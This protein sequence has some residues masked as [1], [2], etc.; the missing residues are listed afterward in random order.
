M[1]IKSLLPGEIALRR[2]VLWLAVCLSGGHC[3]GDSGDSP[4]P[5]NLIQAPV[6]FTVGHRWTNTLGMVFTGVPGIPA[7][8]IW[9][10]RVK[11]YR[12]Y[13]E[14]NPGGDQSWKEPGF[15]QTGDHPVVNVSWDD[16]RAFCA[17]LTKKERAE[18]R[19]K[20]GQKYRLPMDA[21]WSAAVGLEG[22]VG[23]SPRDKDSKIKGVYPWGTRWPPPRG[24]GNYHQSLGV[25][26]YENTAPVGSF[27]SNK[28]D[29][30]DMGGNLWQWC[31]DWHDG[32]QKY[33]VLRGAPWNRIGSVSL[34]SSY[35]SYNIPDFRN[36]S[37]G[38]RCVLVSDAQGRV[39]AKPT[40]G[41]VSRSV[42]A[43]PAPAFSSG[44]RWTNTL[45][46]VFTGV[47]GIPAFSIWDTRVRDYRAYAEA[48]PGGDQSWKEPGFEQTG[49]HPVVNVSWDD[50]RAFC[51]W[52]TK[53]ERAEGRIKVGQKYRLPMDAEWSAA[54]GLEGEVGGSP[55]DKNSKIK[56]AYPWGTQWPAPKGAGNY[57]PSLGGGRPRIHITRG[58]FRCE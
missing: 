19:I 40:T 12:A 58:E 20:V 53:K 31:E 55:R 34:L 45:G 13:A 25:D 51:A 38:F 10:T 5:V 24:A 23:G 21:E 49:D 9:D 4:S 30:Y 27:A 11:D 37:L 46:M 29:L 57:S 2:F 36:Y 43:E 22:E 39:E 3:L 14:A 17:W 8:S 54:V 16:A 28:Y 47:P 52:L 26:D 41:P 44:H 50:A 33:R 1:N 6:S 56:G 7:F 15:E 32:E 42:V 48:S 18:G 35:R